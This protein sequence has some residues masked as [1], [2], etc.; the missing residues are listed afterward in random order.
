LRFRGC[1][2][3]VLLELS[4]INFMHDH[5]DFVCTRKQ[6]EKVLYALLAFG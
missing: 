1:L 2:A 5:T 3:C 6:I 4:E